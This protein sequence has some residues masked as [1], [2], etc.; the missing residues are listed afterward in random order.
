MSSSIR[1]PFTF[2]WLVLSPYGVLSYLL[3]S[4]LAQFIWPDWLMVSRWPYYPDVVEYHRLDLI[5]AVPLASLALA[6]AFKAAV[7]PWFLA[8]PAP[9]SRCILVPA[10]GWCIA[11]FLACDR[12][13]I[14][15][16]V[17][18]PGGFERLFWW[19]IDWIWKDTVNRHAVGLFVCG[20][21]A[22]WSVA[23]AYKPYLKLGN[24]CSGTRTVDR[25]CGWAC[26]ASLYGL[27]LV[28]ADLWLRG[29]LYPPYEESV[30]HSLPRATYLL[31]LILV[32][33][34]VAWRFSVAPGR[35]FPRPGL[36]LAC[37]GA[38]VAVYLVGL[39]ARISVGA[40]VPADL[41]GVFY[42]RGFLPFYL[43]AVGSAVLSMRVLSGVFPAE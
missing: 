9:R 41:G 42:D 34:C 25:M 19:L 3:G 33:A 28:P 23:V 43:S 30:F 29:H 10:I 5:W 2:I 26:V 39:A 37:I 35:G 21:V 18:Q 13:L 36:F 1:G 7:A 40:L 38:G 6:T 12:S 27:L 24:R 20:S 14:L 17:L 8:L 11:Y 15:F 32:Y 22:A 31:L 16:A 4:A